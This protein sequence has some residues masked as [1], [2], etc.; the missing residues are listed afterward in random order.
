MLNVPYLCPNQID[1]LQKLVVYVLCVALDRWVDAIK[2]KL[3]LSVDVTRFKI[4]ECRY[5]R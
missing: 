5:T 4:Q 2:S 1:F 3:C